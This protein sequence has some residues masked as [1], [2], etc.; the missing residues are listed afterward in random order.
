[1][2][3]TYL[4]QYKC[5]GLRLGTVIDPPPPPQP[6]FREM[7]SGAR[8]FGPTRAVMTVA[9]SHDEVGNQTDLDLIQE[10]TRLFRDAGT[11]FAFGKPFPEPVK[12]SMLAA[13]R[14]AR[15]SSA[16]DQG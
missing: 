3:L 7:L 6:L 15:S 5:D 10:I 12:K 16:C 13:L 14:L 8:P 9:A 11:E 2:E 4:L 1:M